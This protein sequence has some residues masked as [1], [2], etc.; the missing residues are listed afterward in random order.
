MNRRASLTVAALAAAVL[1]TA[2]GVANAAGEWHP[3]TIEQS[4]VSNCNFDPETGII[5]NAEF[6]SDPVSIPKTGDVFYVRTIPGRVGNGCGTGMS[7]H[8]EIVAPSGVAP[9]ISASNPVRCN[10]MDIDTSALTPASGCPQEAQSGVYGVAFDQLTLGGATKTQPWP[11]PYGKALVIEIPLR[12]SRGLGG[13]A[14]TCARANGDPPCPASQTADSLQF[15]DKIIDGFGSPWLSPYVGLFVN[16]SA[17]IA[18]APRAIKIGR[19][20]HGL[21]I[22]V[23]V[24]DGGS[25]VIADLSV[26]RFG[27]ASAKAK[28][29]ATRTVRGARA[30]TLAVKLKPSRAATRIL[31]RVRR[32]LKATLRVR[33]V[34]PDGSSRSATAKLT[35]RP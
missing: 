2:S 22:K 33:V 13:L 25:R 35:L 3:G 28:V 30:G 20:I 29:I 19:L 21:G 18:A 7:V 26:K 8:V 10:Y 24:A 12:S 9:A 6:R 17:L 16:K 11:L 1:G 5:A 4:T 32:P 15:A 34:P 23:N 31:R 27:A 14:P